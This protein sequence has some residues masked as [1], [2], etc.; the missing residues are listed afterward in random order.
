MA[1]NVFG[2]EGKGP[3]I[4]GTEPWTFYFKN[5]LLNFNIWFPLAL[6]AGPLLVLQVLLRPQIFWVRSLFYV[7]P[8]YLWFAIFTAQPHK[9]ERF[10]YPAYPFLVL[11]ASTTLGVVISFILSQRS[12]LG[13]RLK[14]VAKAAVFAT[15]LLAVNLGIL[16]IVGMVT[17]YGAPISVFQALELRRTVSRGDSVCLGKEWYRFPSSFFLPND[18]RAKFVKSEFSGLLPS[19]FNENRSLG[20]FPGTWVTPEGMNELNIEDPGKYTNISECRFLV[21]SYFPGNPGS[22]LEPNYVLEK[23]MWEEVRCEDFLDGGR[24]SLLPRTVWIPNLPFIPEP[25][26]RHWGRFC[27]LRRR[28]IT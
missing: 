6:A 17:A 22:P 23:D 12:V 8:F 26:Q 11:N 5:L 15:I 21:D 19:E 7:L 28:G 2:G 20:L 25:L 13:R 10:M 14:F 18:T 9:E 4:Y 1:Y 24:T 16:R 27:L 3:E